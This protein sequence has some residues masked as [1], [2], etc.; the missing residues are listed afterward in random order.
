VGAAL[1]LLVRPPALRFRVKF[2]GLDMP[3]PT[4]KRPH[5]QCVR[6]DLPWFSAP[7]VDFVPPVPREDLPR[8][9]AALRA[10]GPVVAVFASVFETF[11]MAAHE[12]G[13]L[14]VPLVLSDIAAYDAWNGAAAVHRFRAGNATDLAR[15]LSAALADGDAPPREPLRYDDALLPYERAIG[16][17]TGADA[18]AGA[19]AA[20]QPSRLLLSAVRLACARVTDAVRERW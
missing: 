18:N 12:L 11:G 5:S 8:L 6:A 3:C 13:A 4:H 10:E 7:P 16:T 14:G 1:A 9:V 20:P 19:V 17:G 15:A 2:V